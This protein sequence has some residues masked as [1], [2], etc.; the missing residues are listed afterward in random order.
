E[1]MPLHKE[2]PCFIF[3]QR[4]NALEGIRQALWLTKSKLTK[5]LSDQVLSLALN[6]A[7]QIENQDERV[8]IAIRNGC[9]WDTTEERPSR[10][11]FCVALL[12]NLIHLCG[13]LQVSH[14]GLGRRIL[15]EQCSLAGTWS[16]GRQ[17][18]P[19]LKSMA[20][21]PVLAGEEEVKSTA[22]HVL[23]T[24][25]PISPTIDLQF[26]K[27]T[28]Q[29]CRFTGPTIILYKRYLKTYDQ[30]FFLSA[31]PLQIPSG[32]SG[33]KSKT[34]QKFLSLYLNGAV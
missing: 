33:Y 8:E 12:K 13:S 31:L 28:V 26:T 16:R 18:R 1:E 29:L 21:L 22:D 4:T 27:Y 32:L 15:V 30:V 25:Y 34:F 2:K 24:F 11:K 17:N 3:N 9:F 6:S 23:E 19:L 14:P 7:N 5:G 10:E 20:P